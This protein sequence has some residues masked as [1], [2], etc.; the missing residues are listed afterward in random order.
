[1]EDDLMIEEFKIEAAEMFEN[2]EEGLL[3]IDKGLDFN[4]NYN[5]PLS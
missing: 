2:A 5:R 4:S 3:N 1:M